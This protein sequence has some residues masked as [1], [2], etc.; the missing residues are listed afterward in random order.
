MWPRTVFS[1]LTLVVVQLIPHEEKQRSKLRAADGCWKGTRYPVGI[2][3]NAISSSVCHC[4][5]FI[6]T[7][8]FPQPL[9]SPPQWE[10]R[11]PV[12]TGGLCPGVL[13]RQKKTRDTE[14]TNK[15]S[16]TAWSPQNRAFSNQ[17]HWECSQA[18]F[19]KNIYTYLYFDIFK[20]LCLSWSLHSEFSCWPVK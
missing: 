15:C 17:E 2:P 16:A 13:G 4:P 6:S 10:W 7:R 12:R 19:L 20:S 18:A 14:T 5:D 3:C 11:P 9:S 8:C 1:S